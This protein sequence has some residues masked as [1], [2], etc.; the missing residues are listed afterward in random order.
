M[1]YRRGPKPQLVFQLLGLQAYD[2]AAQASLDG[3]LATCDL[4]AILHCIGEPDSAPDASH[5]LVHLDVQPGPPEHCRKVMVLASA[6]VSRKLAERADKK[7]MDD[8]RHLV[9][10]LSLE[11]AYRA[12]AGALFEAYAHRRLQAGGSFKVR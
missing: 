2:E 3:A 12:A 11:P 8:L 10:R 9:N 7:Q 1:I 4:S 5:K 6:Y